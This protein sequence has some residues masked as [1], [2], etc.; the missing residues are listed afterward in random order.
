MKKIKLLICMSMLLFVTG[1]LKKNLISCDDFT[2][3]LKDNSYTVTDIS[4]QYTTYDYIK[5]VVIAQSDDG[6]QIEFYVLESKD[7]AKKLFNNNLSKFESLKEGSSTEVS[8][9]MIN[10][11]TY[12]LTSGGYYMYISRVDNTLLYVNVDEQYKSEVKDIVKKLG[13]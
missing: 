1:C 4:E 13:Y 2:E 12:A 3:I 8:T 10:Y 7:S 11:S 6:F 9:N 5:N